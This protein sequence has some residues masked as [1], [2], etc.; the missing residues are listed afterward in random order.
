MTE[1]RREMTG[2]RR[3]RN[4]LIWVILG[5]AALV[6]CASVF[7]VLYEVHLERK[8]TGRYQPPGRLV[9]I[10]SHRIHLYCTGTGEPPVVLLSGS[11]L[12]YS[13]WSWE[14]VQADLSETTRVCSY[15]RAG[16]GWSDRG[17]ERPSANQTVEELFAL[18][19]RSEIDG[20]WVVVGHSLG[21]LHAQ[22]FMNLHPEVVAAL[23]LVDATPDD[24]FQ[25]IPRLVELFE[26]GPLDASSSLRRLVG[27]HRLSI[28]QVP[29]TDPTWVDRQL[30]QTVKHL[31]TAAAEW[32]GIPESAEQVRAARVPWGDIPLLVLV[33]G[34]YTPPT[35]W[36]LTDAEKSADKEANI[37]M[38]KE[39]AGRSSHGRFEVVEGAG[40]GIP[41]ERPEVVVAAVDSIIR[42][43]RQTKDS[44]R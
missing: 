41:W 28:E 8:L 24:L 14:G 36:D 5:L 7:G 40:H 35:E 9:D 39:T 31:R 23:V 26:P 17:P 6:V 15:D 11:G 32:S 3:F 27:L 19:N 18:L 42:I 33:A 34:R 10:G 25:R 4:F 21:G 1:G 43:L 20:P 29:E 12:T 2:N 37:A 38:Y 16:L 30:Y 13:E 44:P 22:H